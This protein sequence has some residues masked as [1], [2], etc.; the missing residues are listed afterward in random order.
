VW[1]V[2]AHATDLAAIWAFRR[3]K[4]RGLEPLELVS[5]EAL[6]FSLRW[7]HRIGAGGVAT[8]I[9][10]ADGRLIRSD[11]VRGVLNR[12][13]AVPA[14]HWRCASTRERDYALEE[15][16]AFHTSWL[17]SLP[18]LVLNRPTPLSLCGAWRH[19]ADWM[20]L[21]ARAGLRTSRYRMASV[22]YAETA[23]ASLRGTAKPACERRVITVGKRV[24]GSPAPPE[25]AE[26]CVR[27][28]KL[29]DTQLLGVDFEVGAG[30]AWSFAGASPMPDLRLGA[31]RLVELLLE[32]FRAG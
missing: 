14:E 9:R 13:T 28:A 31:E 23:S 32:V 11:A 17:H 30:D 25:V 8:E 2:L 15:L 20:L 29:A 7:E 19:E 5:A 1:L 10:L 6:A 4:A 12:L 21:A 3:L 26:G 24:C 16:A 18:C 22:A 27:L